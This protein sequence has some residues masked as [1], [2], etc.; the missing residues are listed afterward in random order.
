MLTLAIDAAT[1]EGSVAVLRGPEVLA[2]RSIAMRGAHE[3]RLMPAVAA[4]LAD[5]G[6][7][8]AALARIV[9]GAGPGSFTSLRIA[10][11]IAKGLAS[12]LARPLHAV[13]SLALMVAA[14]RRAPG[15]YAAVLGAMRGE[16]FVQRVSVDASGRVATEGAVQIIASD[17]LDELREEEDLRV[18]GPGMQI[19]A[20]PHARGVARLAPGAGLTSP[21]DL[22]AWEPRYGRVAEAQ[23]RWEAAHGRPL[24]HG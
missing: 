19:D 16:L 2:E 9:C 17:A 15:R 21:V 5:A 18:V 7:A 11:A 23:A 10:G 3:E 1:Y 8:P 24:S 13:S 20:V 12:G 6:V 4:T 22:V 14:D